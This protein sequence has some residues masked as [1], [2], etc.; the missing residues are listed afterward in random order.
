MSPETPNAIKLET[1][2]FDALPM[3][4]TSILYETDRVDEFAPVKNADVEGK[5]ETDSPA[6]SKQ[7]QTERAA[8]WLEARGVTVPRHAD[9]TVN[10]T[11]EIKQTTAI[12]P[13]DLAEIDLPNTVEA[14]GEL[15]L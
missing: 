10:A 14:G 13:E 1:F 3:T 12:Y 15:L 2:V 4:S 11:I 9:G 5:I 8:R 7:L 6:S